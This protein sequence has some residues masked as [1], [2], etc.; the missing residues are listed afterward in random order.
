VLQGTRAPL[1]LDLHNLYA[2]AW[3]F[4]RDPEELLRALP[5]A[6]VRSV[7][8]AGGCIVRDATGVDRLVDDHV[9]DP[10]DAV[11][12]LLQSLAANATGG[13]TVI[14]ERDGNFP[15]F[16]AILR[17]LARARAALERGRQLQ[18][19]SPAAAA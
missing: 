1:L 2:N 13:L 8:L 12:D 17:Q 7:H 15:D 14:L 6:Q 18:S 16:S 19:A 10:P 3:N 11:Y 5:L 4:G 9:H